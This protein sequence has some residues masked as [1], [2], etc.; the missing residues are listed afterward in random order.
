MDGYTLAEI[1]DVTGLSP[2]TVRYYVAQGLAPAPGRQ[3]SATRYPRSTLDRLRLA[4]GMRDANVPLAEIR[5]RLAALS[6]TEVAALVDTPRSSVVLEAVIPAFTESWSSDRAIAWLKRPSVT[7]SPTAD[8]DDRAWFPARRDERATLE[9]R[10]LG[11]EARPGPRLGERSQWERI[12]ISQD[13]ELHVRRPLGPRD[14]R[15]VSR[16]VE[17][18]GRSVEAA[19]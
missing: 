14:N 10:G 11:P 15:L 19:P 3:G 8:V 6:D 16:L 13:I 7:G 17:L 5:R 9:K 4:A 1:A 12:A 18:A 2:R